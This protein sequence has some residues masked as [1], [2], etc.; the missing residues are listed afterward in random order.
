MMDQVMPT[1]EAYLAVFASEGLL[2][3]VDEQMGFELI[4]VAELGGAELADVRTLAS[5]NAQMAAE[6]RYLDELAVAMGA[7]VR[8]L[9]RV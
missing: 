8:L 4:A 2:V 1:A 5:V 7:L 6:V 9:A 3:L